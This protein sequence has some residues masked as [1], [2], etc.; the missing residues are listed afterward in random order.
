M[1]RVEYYRRMYVRILGF[2]SAGC[3]RSSITG[4]NRID[5]DRL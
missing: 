2:G 1:E 3:T 5:L 4:F